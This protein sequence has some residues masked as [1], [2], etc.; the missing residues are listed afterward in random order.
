MLLDL[1]TTHALWTGTAG[2]SVQ[3]I[4]EPYR[5][6]AKYV[7]VPTQLAL[8][9]T[10]QRTLGPLDFGFAGQATLRRHGWV[11]IGAGV[12]LSYSWIEGVSVGLRAGGRRTETD[13]ERPVALGG[14]I[15]F[16]RFSVEYGL[17]FFNGD[18]HTHR[19]T[20]RVR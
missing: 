19:L 17:G 8:G 20:M 11:G 4:A 14:T 3:N 13:D 7:E 9:W 10:K 15:V 2:L 1:G 5:M 16:D 18:K 12:D 6:G